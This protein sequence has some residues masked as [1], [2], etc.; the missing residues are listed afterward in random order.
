MKINPT[1]QALLH[2]KRRLKTARRGHALLKEKR[3]S[4]VR[5]FIA[6]YKETQRLRATLKD[7]F[8]ETLARLVLAQGLLGPERAEIALAGFDYAAR[9]L[10]T[11]KNMMGV[12]LPVFKV[13]APPA[14]AS[15]SGLPY[16]LATT[17]VHLDR[18]LKELKQTYPCFLVLAEKE[19][20]LI[21][22]AEEIEKTRRRV[23][24]L[25]H[26]L[27]PEM[28]KAADYVAAVLEERE[29]SMRTVLMK[30]KG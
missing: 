9:V 22:L 11:H 28:E 7:T 16:S 12:H 14:D 13:E 23:N 8:G 27:I 29:R 5:D 17:P 1:R 6:L 26:V 3:D 2:L 10:V 24:A 19:N 20:A 4:L 30:L 15:H 21:L 25:E 18:G